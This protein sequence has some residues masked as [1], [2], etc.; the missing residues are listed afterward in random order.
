MEEAV[1]KI[2]LTI[3]GIVVASFLL[4]FIEGFVG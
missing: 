2:L 1:S 3:G 4:G